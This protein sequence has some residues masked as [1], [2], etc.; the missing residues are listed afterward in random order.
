MHQDCVRPR[1]LN[2]RH[3]SAGWMMKEAVRVSLPTQPRRLV[4]FA[5]VC[6]CGGGIASIVPATVRWA[7]GGHIIFVLALLAGFSA[8]WSP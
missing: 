6:L 4:L 3:D 2:P 5:F 1:M 7:E 8:L